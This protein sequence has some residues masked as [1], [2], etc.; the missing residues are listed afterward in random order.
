MSTHSDFEIDGLYVLLSDRGDKSFTFHW[1][2]YLHQSIDSGYI[3]DL[4]SDAGSTNWRF[5]P[6]PSENV[7]GSRR[8][9]V[10]LKIGALDSTMHQS[11][12]HRLEQIPLAYSTR[13]NENITC[14]VWVKE[15]LFALDNEGYIGITSSVDDL[16]FE[17]RN[18][19][20]ANKVGR[21]RTIRPSAECH[22]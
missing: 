17:A 22:F 2:L 3:Y 10:A 11:L 4:L 6:R 8:V 14:R 19:A 9:L 7:I 13:F 1:G 15:A 20:L 18:L 12:L 16:E 21:K 5:D